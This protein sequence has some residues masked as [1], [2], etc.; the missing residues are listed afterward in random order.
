MLKSLKSRLTLLYVIILAVILAVFA[1]SI[2]VAARLEFQRDF[3]ELLDREARVFAEHVLGRFEELAGGD[4]SSVEAAASALGAVAAVYDA[5]GNAWWRMPGAVSFERLRPAAASETIRSRVGRTSFRFKV[6][7]VEDRRGRAAWVAFGLDEAPFERRLRRLL[8]YF[9]LFIPAM[10]LVAGYVGRIFVRGALSPVDELRLQAEQIQRSNLSQRVPV[11]P[12]KGEIRDLAITLND[13]LAR[14]ERVFEQVTAFTANA[15]HELKTPLA[16]LRTEIELALEGESD[17]A[18]YQAL[19]AS[20]AE[21]VSRMTRIV[22]NLLLLAQLDSKQAALRQETVDLSHVTQEA[23]GDAQILGEAHGVRVRAGLIAPHVRVRGDTVMLRRVILNLLENGVKYNHP[24]GEVKISVWR[25]DAT[26]RI[27]VTDTGVGIPVESVPHLFD[28]FYRVDR[29]RG[30]PSGDR[31]GGHGLGLSISKSLVEA[32]GGK[33][34][35]T[36]KEGVGTT[37]HVTLPAAR[38]GK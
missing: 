1:S 13:M 2:Y 10:L 28:R 3:D 21:E 7:S 37:V 9:A 18:A 30:R 38:E 5:E 29:G 11:P 26:A 33:I 14:L 32:H 31:V 36:S 17:A 35:M 15:S 4:A 25:E 24:G 16:N 6:R 8:Y 27:E 20:V 12:T 22:D 19:L 23:L 34:E